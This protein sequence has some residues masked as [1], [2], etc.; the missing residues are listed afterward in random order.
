MIA[1]WSRGLLPGLSIAFTGLLA[2]APL[3]M[4][5]H[6]GGPTSVPPPPPGSSTLRVEVVHPDG[7]DR[8]A[9][10]KVDL[11]ALDPNG[12]PGFAT[13]QTDAQGRF[14]FSSISGNPAIVYLV[15]V[16]YREI[17][18]GERMTFPR[19]PGGSDGS[20]NP[21]GAVEGST[22]DLRIEVSDP[23]DQL[24][25]L[26]ILEL[27][28]R[29]DWMGDR[30]VV[31]EI[32]KLENPTK[33]V[34]L[35]PERDSARAVTIR[36]L[37]ADAQDFAL[38]PTSAG[39]GAG[40]V[41]GAVLFWGPLY[42]GEQSVEYQY[43]LPVD[44]LAAT[45]PV[46]MRQAIERVVVVAGTQGLGA[47][48]E[49][50]IASSDVSGDVGQRL[51]TWARAGLPAG[52]SLE[53]ALTLPETR[54]DPSLVKMPRA[55]LW[56][57][58]DDALISGRVDLNL[59]VE[60]GPPV[61]GSPEAPLFHVSIPKGATLNGVAP[62]AEA[63]GLVPTADG[64]FDVIGP[65]SPGKT[66]LGYAYRIPTASGGTNLDLRWPLEVSTLNVLIADTGL[67]LGSSRLHRRRPFR[68]GTR[69]YLHREAYNVSPT[70]VVDLRLAPLVDSGLP[71]SAT[72]GL[73][74]VAAAGGVFFLVAP[75]RR[76]ATRETEDR[77]AALP[78]QLE[79]ESVYVTIQDLDHDFETGK[80]E[81]DD[82]ESMRAA[83]R[84]QAIELL[85]Q[86][87]ALGA[88]AAADP[89]A[90]APSRESGGPSVA[91]GA[92][93]PRCGQAVT[94][95][96]KFCSHCGADLNPASEQAG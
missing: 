9:D 79:R 68:S 8:V 34:V 41:D 59:E 26:T 81:R 1:R 16:R 95:T 13:G 60:P 53:I 32:V 49:R 80:V 52:T 42:P 50:L 46:S 91:T 2:A 14:S 19:G 65:L 55:D 38:G 62:E 94:P 89:V 30:I 37:P 92:F 74:L 48:G 5:Q 21:P 54:R 71:R 58:V 4:A 56:L 51:Q 39:D 73:T 61:A 45:F 36:P 35:M 7:P 3:A 70:E 44:G 22:A 96:W 67:E 27:R 82:Y 93:C 10:L 24:G 78:V 88:Q 11:Y 85:R 75:L 6:T 40:I 63:L 57:E 47:S 20:A 17:P 29:L 90:Q 43:S 31:R 15:G 86:E 25:P 18:F 33:K 77:D 66:N 64:G 28:A 12:Q 72:L 69:N 23:T 83:L 84:A 87:K 76:S